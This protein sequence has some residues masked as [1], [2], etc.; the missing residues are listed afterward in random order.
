M[1]GGYWVGVQYDDKVGKNDGCFT[2][3]AGEKRRFFTCPP[4]HGG[5][6]LACVLACL[7]DC[8]TNSCFDVSD[9]QTPSNNRPLGPKVR[10][11]KASL[12]SGAVRARR[13]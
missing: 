3:Q 10:F 2:N 7:P 5:F 12:L 4:G 6:V 11:A 8:G 9:F 13:P 1:P